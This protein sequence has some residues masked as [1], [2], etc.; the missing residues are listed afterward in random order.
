MKSVA[1]KRV[2]A[3]GPRRCLNLISGQAG[4]VRKRYL[5]RYDVASERAR[6]LTL[7]D[8]YIDS[9]SQDA[10]ALPYAPSSPVIRPRIP[11]VR[12]RRSF[13]TFSSRCRAGATAASRN[14]PAQVRRPSPDPHTLPLVPELTPRRVSAFSRATPTLQTTTIGPAR[15]SRPWTNADPSL[16]PCP[17]STRRR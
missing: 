4:I 9:D 12:P 7:S 8:N 14:R 13:Q 11:T 6:D 5:I 16:A 15:P 10:L 17:P 2:D 3:K 1:S